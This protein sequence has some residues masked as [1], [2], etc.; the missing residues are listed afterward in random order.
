MPA[1]GSAPGLV[2]PCT[3]AQALSS[4][5]EPLATFSLLWKLGDRSAPW[6]LTTLCLGTSAPAVEGPQPAGPGFPLLNST[7]E[8]AML[9]PK[10]APAT[11]ME[12][13]LVMG[14]G[15]QLRCW[16]CLL[17]QAAPALPQSPAAMSWCLSVRRPR[18]TGGKTGPLWDALEGVSGN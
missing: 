16:L 9:I 10:A 4:S 1:T 14:A 8:A 3:P 18:I 7:V 5:E 13:L 17:H 11:W 15:P 12:V 6:I 2:D